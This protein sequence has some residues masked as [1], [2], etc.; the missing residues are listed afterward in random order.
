MKK[1]AILATLVAVTLAGCGNKEAATSTE[2]ATESERVEQV[3][4]TTL[5][6]R[7]IQ[8]EISLSSNLQGYHPVHISPSLS[9]KIILYYPEQNH[10]KLNS[11]VHVR[12]NLV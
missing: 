7:E 5:H 9:N 6:A 2:T 10:F 4:T 11:N 3:R 8:R 12:M 1:Q